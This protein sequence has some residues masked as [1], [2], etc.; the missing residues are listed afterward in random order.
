MEIG[1]IYEVIGYVAS[2]L[3]AISLL[4]TSILRLRII[5]IIGAVIFVVYALLIGSYPVAVVNFVIVLINLYQLNKLFRLEDEFRLLDNDTNSSYLQQFVDFHRDEIEKFYPQFFNTA[6]DDNHFVVFVLR[7]MLPV[8][9]FIA[10]KPIDGRAVV[11][12]DYVIPNYRDFKVGQYLYRQKA[13]VFKSEGIREL[14][15]YSG[16]DAHEKYLQRMGFS[17]DFATS[18]RRLYR[19]SL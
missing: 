4:M 1:M 8:G 6:L 13:D 10:S 12:L 17:R 11:K 16:N 5:N 7:N 3:V 9:L 19:L 15:S 18:D 2:A 14:I